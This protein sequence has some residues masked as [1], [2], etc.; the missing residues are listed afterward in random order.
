MRERFLFLF[1]NNTARVA[2][3]CS[4][5]KFRV[6]QQ[7]PST[8]DVREA[9]KW[10]QR[11]SESSILTKC[12]DLLFT[13]SCLV[14]ALSARGAYLCG[15]V[16]ALHEFKSGSGSDQSKHQPASS[17]A[18]QRPGQ[19]STAGICL[20]WVSS[21]PSGDNFS[22]SDHVKHPAMIYDYLL[23][24]RIFAGSFKIL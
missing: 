11:R 20:V 22:I 15:A 6:K 2:K 1:L 19:E 10:W 24:N 7:Q 5:V 14:D 23:I 12:T 9:A 21:G 18:Q 13:L 8:L 4:V 17:K 3:L 16:T